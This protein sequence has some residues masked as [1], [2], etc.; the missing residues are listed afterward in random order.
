MLAEAGAADYARSGNT[1]VN[2]KLYH[3][4]AELPGVVEQVCVIGGTL[5]AIS[6]GKPTFKDVAGARSSPHG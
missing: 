6:L 1:S 2:A 5:E 3:S 4:V